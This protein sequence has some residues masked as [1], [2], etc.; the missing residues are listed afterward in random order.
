M[1]K[2]SILCLAFCITIFAACGQS[3]KA[4]K[5][6]KAATVFTTTDAKVKAQINGLLIIYF[7]LKDALVA[8]DYKTAGEKAKDFF[9]AMDNVETQ[10]MTAEERIF[11]TD[12]S[13][14]ISYDAEHIK[15]A[16]NIDHMREHFN[17]FSANL[18]LVIKAYQ[19]NGGETVY[20][21]Y[22]PMQKATWMSKEEAIKNPYYGSQMLT[23]GSVKETVK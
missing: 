8:S 18:F 2:L 15:N 10:R 6:T 5:Q 9:K 1:K 4:T 19:A 17:S 12:I 22:C 23:C 14:K 16:P 20:N 21:D 11:Y 7:Q 13:A 3:K